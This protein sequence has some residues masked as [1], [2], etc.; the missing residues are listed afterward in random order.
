MQFSTKYW[1]SWKNYCQTW[2]LTF[3]VYQP[4][5]QGYLRLHKGSRCPKDQFYPVLL[6][7]QLEERPQTD[8]KSHQQGNFP[9]DFIKVNYLLHLV[10]ISLNLDLSTQYQVRVQLFQERHL[11]PIVAKRIR[12]TRKIYIFPT[13]KFYITCAPLRPQLLLTIWNLS[14]VDKKAE[15]RTCM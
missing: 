3:H 1:T 14:S 12:F 15:K 2:S 5:W 11:R 6:L 4:H 7:M 13:I 9:V 10:P 8:H